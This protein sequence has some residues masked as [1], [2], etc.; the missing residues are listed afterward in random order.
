MLTPIVTERRRLSAHSRA[1]AG[2]ASGPASGPSDLHPIGPAV[3]EVD[4][5]A[6]PRRVLD[7]P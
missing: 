7:E 2:D 4:G 6:Q 3:N 1:P 5:P